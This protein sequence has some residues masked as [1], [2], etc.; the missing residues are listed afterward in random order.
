MDVLVLLFGLVLLVVGSDALVRGA[1]A[2]ARR[3][4]ISPLVVGL[5]VVAL[6]TSA[7]EL[8]V[9]V[10]AA[11]RGSGGLSF[12]NVIGSNLANMG[13][14]VGVAALL[15]PLDIQTT[16]V[17]RELPMMLLATAV[18]KGLDVPGFAEVVASYQLTGPRLSGIVAF[19]WPLG[20]LF[21]AAMLLFRPRRLGAMLATVLHTVLLGVVAISLLRGLEIENC[22]CFGVFL[23]RPLGF[24]TAIEDAVMLGLSALAWWIAR[25]GA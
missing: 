6:G 1:A 8:A 15:R 7:P 10:T 11:F 24:V 12:G 19:V 16:V 5:T 18:G 21:A 14:V 23:A 25:K 2:L 4:G 17:R 20:E 3:L 22:G 13:L 9:N